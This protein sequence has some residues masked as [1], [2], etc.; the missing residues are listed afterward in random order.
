MRKL[1]LMLPQQTNERTETVAQ[2]L[3]LNQTNFNRIDYISIALLQFF[4]FLTIYTCK[5]NHNGGRVRYTFDY[6][7]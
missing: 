2:S 4:L 6:Y 5:H 3:N 1:L 7:D